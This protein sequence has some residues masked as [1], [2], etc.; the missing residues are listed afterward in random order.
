M[1][2]DINTQQLVELAL[3]TLSS[4][5][6]EEIQEEDPRAQIALDVLAQY[7]MLQNPSISNEQLMEEINTME[8]EYMLNSL[9]NKGMI[10]IEFSDDGEIRYTA[11]ELGKRISEGCEDEVDFD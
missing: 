8:T 5:D 9:V 11:T 7:I 1:E 4:L 2:I 10:E 3:F 6:E